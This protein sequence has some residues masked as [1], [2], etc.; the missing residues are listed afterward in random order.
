MHNGLWRP[1]VRASLFGPIAWCEKWYGAL[2]MKACMRMVHPTG[3][4]GGSTWQFTHM[5]SAHRKR[6][7]VPLV[8][9]RG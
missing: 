8:L 3:S 1:D 2:C 4:S 9:W 5:V 6:C 7:V